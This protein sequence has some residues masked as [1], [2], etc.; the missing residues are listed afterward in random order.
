MM[1]ACASSVRANNA[2]LYI[3]D[4]LDVVMSFAI[5]Q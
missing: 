3:P 5:A 4:L 2:L 1:L